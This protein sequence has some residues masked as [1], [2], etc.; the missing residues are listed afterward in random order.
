MVSG[1]PVPARHRCWRPQRLAFSQL[2][3]IVVNAT[4]MP[5]PPGAQKAKRASPI[6]GVPGRILDSAET[7]FAQL[8]YHGGSLRKIARGAGTSESGVLRFFESKEDIFLAVIERSLELLLDRTHAA[9]S[10]L[11]ES[12]DA[13][14]ELLAI[15]T[16]AFA[17]Y[18]EAPNKA[19][20]IFS[21]C[22]LSIRMLRSTE[23]R[24][25]MTLPGM[26][27]LI[28]LVTAVFVSGRKEGTFRDIDP[29]AAREV[30]FGAIEGTILGWLLASEPTGHYKAS[31]ARKVLAV[32]SRMIDGL[33]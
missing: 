3:Q 31:S 8:G 14:D 5:F 28:A 21:E 7:Q 32:V 29:I 24:T 33:R 10:A 13:G 9:L 30:F 16:A 22:G 27:E 2:G 11:P 12:A 1:S 4:T 15:C 23:G 20:L 25:L 19:A 18:D 17:L 6:S 26:T